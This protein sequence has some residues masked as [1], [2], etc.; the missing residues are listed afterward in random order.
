MPALPLLLRNPL[1]RSRLLRL[2]L[3]PLVAGL[4]LAG[5]ASPA[6]A[7][8]TDRTRLS[9]S[10]DIALNQLGDNYRY[11]AAGPDRFDCSGL[12]YYSY[13]RAGFSGMPRTSRSQAAWLGKVRKSNLRRGDL[14]YFSNGGGVYHA[15]I[16]L[17]WTRRGA[18]MVDAGSSGG[19]VR[20]RTAWTSAWFGR[21]IR[22]R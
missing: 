8:V 9:R 17:R 4:M 11:G 14:M 19:E 7:G 5:T 15:G 12:I 16:F 1:L 10:V 18:L 13:R 3:L 21:T 6:S 20:R 2:L 22:W